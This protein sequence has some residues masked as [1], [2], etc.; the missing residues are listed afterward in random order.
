M[1][2]PGRINFNSSVRLTVTYSDETGEAFDPTSV[3]FD[4]YSPEGRQTSYVYGVSDLL[5]RS[6]EGSYY[7]DIPANEVGRWDYR[8]YATDDI[9]TLYKEGQF[10]VDESRWND[11]S[12]RAYQL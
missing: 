7:I 5:Q 6:A 9:T 10:Q 11:T 1:L 2:R 4:S 12:R 3:S 8:W